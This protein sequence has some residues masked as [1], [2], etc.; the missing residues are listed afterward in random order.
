MTL[1]DIGK[2]LIL[3]DDKIYFSNIAHDQ[4]VI[5]FYG[6]DI[7]PGDE[8]VSS[9]TD[10]SESVGYVIG[11]GDS[12]DYDRNTG[13]FVVQGLR[14][15]NENGPI[16][17]GDLLTTSTKPGYFMKQSD[18][19]VRSYTAGRAM[20][21]SNFGEDGTESNFYCIMMCG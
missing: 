6:F 8:R 11:I 12:Y 9:I 20:R 15:C 4:R 10:A 3:Q 17:I 2:A 5:G 1:D 18:D 7:V 13:D 19:L 16:R 21:D 14:V